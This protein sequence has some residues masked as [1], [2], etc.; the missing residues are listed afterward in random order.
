MT[1]ICRPQTN[2]G[3]IIPFSGQTDSGEGIEL[4]GPRIKVRRKRSQEGLDWGADPTYIEAIGDPRVPDE[5]QSADRAAA[6]FENLPITGAKYN[7]KQKC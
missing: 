4:I 7:T 6:G 2:G 5:Y 1:I 3:Q